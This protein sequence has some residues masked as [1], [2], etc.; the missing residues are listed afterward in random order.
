MSYKTLHEL[1]TRAAPNQMM[2]YK[3]SLLVLKIFNDTKQSM[4][5]V[6]LNFQKTYN[7]RNKNVQVC[8]DS[9]YKVGN[10]NC[11]NRL[12]VL[13][14]KIDP[15]W[16]NLPFAT[17]NIKCKQNFSQLLIYDYKAGKITA[18]IC[19]VIC[20]SLNVSVQFTSHFIANSISHLY[21][22]RM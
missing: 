9:K 1:N 11:V 2:T 19:A 12:T 16:L 7:V 15:N 14:R 18:D 20:T 13:N 6:K 17:Y 22:L 21:I 8:D 4:E 5:W 3:H 10:N